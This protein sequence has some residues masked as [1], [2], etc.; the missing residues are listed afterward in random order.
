ML[1]YAIADLHGRY[2][3]LKKAQ[4]RIKEDNFD[5]SG[6]DYKVIFLGD[7]IDRGPQSKEVIE[8]LMEA[9]VISLKGNHEDMAVTVCSDPSKDHINWWIGNGG[10][11]T[12]HSYGH[13]YREYVDQYSPSY[14]DDEHLKWM[15]NLPLYYE[16][17]RHVFVHAGIPTE[18]APLDRQNT[19]KMMWM[20]YNPKD[21]GGWKGKHVVHGHHQ[22]ADGPHE[23][24]DRTDLDTFAWYT[25]RLVIGVFS[26][27]HPGK[28]I[29]Y[30][31]VLGDDYAKEEDGQ[32][33]SG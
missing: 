24:S 3:L 16:T 21:H 15:A 9:D 25:G 28:A 4:Q 32:T 5:L 29:R 7:Y 33:Y 13:P 11:K 27:E 8:H 19:E 22:F 30:L 26:S 14:M 31:E 18:D 2:D 23:W 1:Y 17:E 12:L 10:D 6:E 20:L